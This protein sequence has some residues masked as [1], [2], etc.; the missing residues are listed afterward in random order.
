MSDRTTRQSTPR[1]WRGVSQPTAARDVL[2]KI[3][4]GKQHHI[5]QSA[6]RATFPTFTPPRHYMHTSSSYYSHLINITSTPNIHTSP[7]QHRHLAWLRDTILPSLPSS[8]RYEAI[9]RTKQAT[10][11]LDRTEAC[12]PPFLDG[13]EKQHFAPHPTTILAVPATPIT[14]PTA[15]A[16]AIAA[17]AS[18]KTD[19]KISWRDVAEYRKARW[20]DRLQR[21]IALGD[22]VVRKVP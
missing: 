5:R 19:C 10:P 13:T 18:A 12:R 6:R 3:D 17:A 21:S 11:T 22:A 7:T 15:A 4:G 14:V 9:H 16:G 2:L 1:T 20:P 8:D